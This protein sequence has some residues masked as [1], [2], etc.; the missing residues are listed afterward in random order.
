MQWSLYLGSCNFSEEKTVQFIDSHQ[1][2][3]LISIKTIVRLIDDYYKNNREKEA[4]LP[5]R[6]FIN[7]GQNST[8]LMPAF[9][10]NFYSAKV[11]GIAPDNFK[12]GE[13]TLQGIIALFKRSTME[14]LLLLDAG[15]IT[16]IRTGAISG[17]SIRYLAKDDARIAG[18]IGTGA[19]GW[20]HLQAVCET[21]PIEKILL[22][23]RNQEKLEL[24]IERAKQKY[25][26]MEFIKSNPLDILKKADIIITTTTSTTPV[27]PDANGISLAGKHFIGAGSYRSVM[28]EIPNDII[29]KVDHI[30]VDTY[31]IFDGCG[32]MQ[33]AKTLGYSPSNTMDNKQMVAEGESEQL[34]KSATFFKSG[35]V[36]VFDTL[37]AIEVYRNLIK[38]GTSSY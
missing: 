16:A 9:F 30:V 27:L 26:D 6:L 1:I 21:R 19:Q 14:P 4:F 29:E 10:A 37:T 2:E 32:E 23:N 22:D 31:N 20:T 24:F 33:Y 11:I 7:D 38:E 5:R 13:P 3:S 18:I 28:Q 15:S 17:L 25:P 8:L 36:A 12:I 35:G 34:K